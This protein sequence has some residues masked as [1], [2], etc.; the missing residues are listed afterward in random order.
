[1]KWSSI[2]ETAFDALQRFYLSQQTEYSQR[3]RVE[4]F[5]LNFFNVSEIYLRLKWRN[6]PNKIVWKQLKIY[7]C[8]VVDW[9]NYASEV[10]VNSLVERQQNKIGESDMIIEVN[11]SMFTKQNNSV[12]CVL[13]QQRIFGGVCPFK[14]T[15]VFFSG[16]QTKLRMYY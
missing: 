15:N 1:M 9:N 16:Y 12:Q 14:N 4:S 10:C 8:T 5:R 2:L 13:R 11:E 6:D 7:S 3:N